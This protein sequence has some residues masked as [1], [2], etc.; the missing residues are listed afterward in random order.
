M[1]EGINSVNQNKSY[2]AMN[3]KAWYKSRHR[4]HVM[5][6]SRRHVS[7]QLL[8]YNLEIKPLLGLK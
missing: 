6:S 2:V 8:Y 3:I 4:N 1:E 7:G 5:G